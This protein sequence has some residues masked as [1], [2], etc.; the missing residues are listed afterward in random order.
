VTGPKRG[1]EEA[2][3]VVVEL[4]P[5]SGK[6][7]APVRREPPKEAEPSQDVPI[8]VVPPEAAP[9]Q[10]APE[11]LASNSPSAPEVVV[12]EPGLPQAQPSDPNAY[13]SREETLRVFLDLW[14]KQDFGAMYPMLSEASWKLFSQET[15]ESSL[16][17]AV[18]FRTALREGYSVN[19]LGPERAKV[20]AFKR[21]LLFRTLV[22]RT[23]GVVRE[24]SVWK[25]VW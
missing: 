16:R 8:Q 24:G 23:L 22:S 6:R 19:W 17:K 11:Q 4:P 2:E 15:F 10:G 20:V 14:V 3:V 9:V 25:I 5:A 18:D 21:V 7:K 1:V 12:I 13:V